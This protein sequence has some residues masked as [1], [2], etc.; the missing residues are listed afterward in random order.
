MFRRIKNEFDEVV[1]SLELMPNKEFMD[2]YKKSKEQ[3]KKRYFVSWN[4]L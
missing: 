4:W 1:E 3:I 2:S